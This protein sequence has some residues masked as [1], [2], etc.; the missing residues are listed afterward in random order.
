MPCGLPPALIPRLTVSS[1]SRGIDACQI[2]DAAGNIDCQLDGSASSGFIA[3]YVW[4]LRFDGK[5]ASNSTGNP[6][7]SVTTTCAFFEPSSPGKGQLTVLVQLQL[8]DRNDVRTSPADR[9]IIVST[10]GKCGF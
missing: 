7:S 4:T 8:E 1:P 9:T 10:N 3:R 2:D 6:V 5:E